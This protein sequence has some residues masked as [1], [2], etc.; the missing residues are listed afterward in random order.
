MIFV[1]RQLVKKVRNIIA[2][3][4]TLFVD[5]RKVYN[6]VPQ[7]VLWQVLEKFGVPLF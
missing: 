2:S 5:L 4:N 3:K 6:S 1:T 7:D